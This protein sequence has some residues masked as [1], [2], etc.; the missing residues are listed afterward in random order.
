MCSSTS[1]AI[2]LDRYWSTNFWSDFVIP[3]TM[4]NAY[5][6]PP[7]STESILNFI[8]L[9]YSGKLRPCCCSHKWCT[10][11]RSRYFF[12]NTL[13]QFPTDP[14]ESSIW[15]ILLGQEKILPSSRVSIVHFFEVDILVKSDGAGNAACDTIDLGIPT[16]YQIAD[17]GNFS[18]KSPARPAARKIHIENSVF[19]GISELHYCD[20]LA[21]AATWSTTKKTSH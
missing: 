1:R 4:R 14:Y 19:L 15:G 17:T 10:S 2:I 21:R 5:Q 9:S 3:H 18:L 20:Y 12:G 8:Y 13:L 7:R 6:L 11:M 16:K